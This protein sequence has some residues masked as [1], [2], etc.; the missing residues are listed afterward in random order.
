MSEARRPNI[1]PLTPL[2]PSARQGDATLVDDEVRR[3]ALLDEIG[4]ERRGVVRLVVGGR[5][6]GVRVAGTGGVGG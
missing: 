5:P 1:A 6:C 4:G 2:L 3:Q